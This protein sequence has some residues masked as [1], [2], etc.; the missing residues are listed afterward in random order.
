MVELCYATAP[1][2]RNGRRYVLLQPPTIQTPIFLQITVE[3][4]L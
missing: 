2:L 1:L 4:G 3:I